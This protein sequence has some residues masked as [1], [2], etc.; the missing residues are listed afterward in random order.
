MFDKAEKT[1]PAQQEIDDFNAD[2]I[3]R[4]STLIALSAGI[5]M[6]IIGIYLYNN[7]AASNQGFLAISLTA[8]NLS[9]YTSAIYALLK[10]KKNPANYSQLYLSSAL[11]TTAWVTAALLVAIYWGAPDSAKHVLLI[12]FF[13]ILLGWHSNTL[14]STTALLIVVICYWVIGAQ[15]QALT[16]FNQTLSIIKFPLFILI[17][18]FTVRKLLLEAKKKFFENN[19]LIQQLQT[20]LHIDELT[21]VRNRKGFNRDLPI[22]I[23]T[24]HRLKTPLTLVILDIDFFK[25]YNDSLGH[26]QGDKCLTMVA[27]V[28]NE[29]CLRAVD[30]ISRIGGEEF[31]YILTGSEVEQAALFIDKLKSELHK[32]AIAHPQSSVSE[33]VTFSAGIA[34][35]DS[36]ADDAQSLYKK[37]DQALYRA[38][39]NGRNRYYI[40]D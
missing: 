39:Q 37:A 36:L 38:K 18:S 40:A 27:D 34:Q 21:Q 4:G 30:S 23:N 31:A 14:V 8:L 5:V 28:F 19:Q 13:I 11:L 9:A 29:N 22:A 7:F 26:P 24:A 33:F 10:Y 17:Y 35:Y 16:P 15:F 3:V 1:S 6:I 25:Y 20:T 32:K 12:A 2:L